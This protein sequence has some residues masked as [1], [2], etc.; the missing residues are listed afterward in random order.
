V[1]KMHV[2]NLDDEGTSFLQYFNNQS[3][4]N[5][6]GLLAK[7]HNVNL[8]RYCE[9]LGNLKPFEFGKNGA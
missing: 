4:L 2:S 3:L 6:G 1:E 5:R 7:V 9:K 8:C